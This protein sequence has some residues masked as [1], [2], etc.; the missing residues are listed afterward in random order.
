ML[1]KPNNLMVCHNIL[2]LHFQYP[3]GEAENG[4]LAP[5][6]H[7]HSARLQDPAQGAVTDRFFQ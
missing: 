2:T 7:P 6:L 3:A 5:F 1:D 4:R